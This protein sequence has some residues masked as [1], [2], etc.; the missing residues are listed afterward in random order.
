MYK[1]SQETIKRTMEILTISYPNTKLQLLKHYGIDEERY[2]WTNETHRILKIIKVLEEKVKE[3]FHNLMAGK[4][5]LKKQIT[6][7]PKQQRVNLKGKDR[8]RKTYIK[9]LYVS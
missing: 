9:F 1:D 2:V 4:P 3:Y 7:P 5:S 8:Y 6:L